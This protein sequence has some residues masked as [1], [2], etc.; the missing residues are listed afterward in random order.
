MNFT[1]QINLSAIICI[2]FSWLKVFTLQI[3]HYYNFQQKQVTE[4]QSIFFLLY[5][6]WHQPYSST[7][8]KLYWCFIIELLI[9]FVLFFSKTKNLIIYIL[10]VFITFIIFFYFK[11][12]TFSTKIFF[13]FTSFNFVC[14]IC[15]CVVIFNQDEL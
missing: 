2:H 4:Y 7:Y 3:G 9:S 5:W 12:L 1:Y 10:T 11:F 14:L 13:I 15:V 6:L 8:L